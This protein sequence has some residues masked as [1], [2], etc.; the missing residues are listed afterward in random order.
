VGYYIETQQPK[1]KAE[2]IRQH[3]N[4]VEIS[5]DDAELFAHT[6]RDVAVICVVDNGPFEAAAYCF[7]PEEFRAFSDPTDSR[8]KTWLLVEDVAKVKALTRF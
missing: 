4:G 2:Y 3:L 5:E 7:S 8:P 1:G 6:A